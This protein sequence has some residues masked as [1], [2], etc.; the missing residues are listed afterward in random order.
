MASNTIKSK[1]NTVG[2]EISTLLE[3]EELAFIPTNEIVDALGGRPS[4]YAKLTKRKKEMFEIIE[5]R[6][7]ANSVGVLEGVTAFAELDPVPLPK[8]DPKSS[9]QYAFQMPEGWVERFGKEHAAVRFR[10]AKAGWMNQSE[11]PVALKL[12]AMTVTGIAR[13]R[14]VSRVMPTIKLNMAVVSMP[15]PTLPSII[16]NEDKNK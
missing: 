12:A 10:L 9:Q 13:A 1:E 16:L 7:Y 5:D 11:A 6:L 3:E 14:A 15:A 2:K 8:E 4:A